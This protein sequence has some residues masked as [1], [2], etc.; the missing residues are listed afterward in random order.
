MKTLKTIISILLVSALVFALASCSS[1]GGGDYIESTAEESD[2]L[3]FIPGKYRELTGYRFDADSFKYKAIDLDSD[4]VDEYIAF[5]KIVEITDNNENLITAYACPEGDGDF[6]KIFIFYLYEDTSFRVTYDGSEYALCTA[7][8]EPNYDIC[9]DYRYYGED[10]IE[11]YRSATHNENFENPY[12]LSYECDFFSGDDYLN[13]EY[14]AMTE[15]EFNDYY[16]FC[17]SADSDLYYENG[18]PFGFD[19]FDPAFIQDGAEEGYEQDY[20][21]TVPD[22]NEEGKVTITVTSGNNPEPSGGTAF[23]TPTKAEL[24]ELGQM[25]NNW[26]DFDCSISVATNNTYANALGPGGLYDEYT[27]TGIYEVPEV[28]IDGEPD[29]R[30][31]MYSDYSGYCY[32]IY[33]GQSVDRFLREIMNVEP[34]HNCY[35][36]FEGT[37]YLYYENGNYYLRWDVWGDE[38]YTKYM[39]HTTLPDGKVAV[40]VGLYEFEYF[41]GELL[42]VTAGI[43]VIDGQ[44]VW[45]IYKITKNN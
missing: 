30:N 32:Y 41:Q 39:S 40:K 35:S 33:P 26:G 5:Q 16:N 15:D 42:T 31:E 20:A 43:K 10:E 8:S 3:S 34:N 37:V 18:E 25:A 45:S 2:F 22:N 13:Y 28:I 24:E 19:D 4:G 11:L 14:E 38:D 29:P 9:S 7:A 17:R 6:E 12:T 27:G 44:R 23:P 36:E 1:R 21:E